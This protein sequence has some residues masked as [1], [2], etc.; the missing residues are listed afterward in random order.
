V[1]GQPYHSITHVSLLC[2]RQSGLGCAERTLGD[3]V[4]P[5]NRRKLGRILAEAEAWETYRMLGTDWFHDLDRLLASHAR[6]NIS[7]LGREAA[8]I[9]RAISSPLAARFGIAKPSPARGPALARMLGS[10]SR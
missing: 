3:E 9:S 1:M 2:A 4:M 7:A 6:E 5:T 10:L 8:S